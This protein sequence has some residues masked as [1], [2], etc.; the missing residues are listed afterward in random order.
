MLPKHSKKFVGLFNVPRSNEKVSIYMEHYR[1]SLRFY[2]LL[3]LVLFV[4]WL[5]F[6]I[7]TDIA[8]EPYTLYYYAYFILQR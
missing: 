3:C 6:E 2:I 7:Q 8:L 5:F 1:L 4:G